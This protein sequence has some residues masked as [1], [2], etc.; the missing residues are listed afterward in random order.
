MIGNNY[1][2]IKIMIFAAIGVLGSVSAAS[3]QWPTFDASAIAQKAKSIKQQIDQQ[4]TMIKESSMVGS[5]NSAI[6]DAKA[7][8][9][10]FSLD[11]VKA[12]AAKAEKLK[13]EAE[14]IKKIKE[15]IDKAKKQYEEKKKQFEEYQSKLQEAKSKVTDTIDDAKSKVEDAKGMVNEAKDMAASAKDTVASAGDLAKSQI[16]STM[17]KTGV[18][19]AINNGK[20]TVGQVSGKVSSGVSGAKASVSGTAVQAATTISAAGV[21]GAV[22]GA[23]PVVNRQ[24]FGQG[25]ALGAEKAE[26][27]ALQSGALS[28]ADVRAEKLINAAQTND[29]SEFVNSSQKVYDAGEKVPTAI[30][31]AKLEALSAKPAALEASTTR[32]AVEKLNVSGTKLN[33]DSLTETPA[34]NLKAVSGRVSTAT[35][36]QSAVLAA[37]T[38]VSASPALSETT[39]AS[40]VKAVAAPKAVTLERS[41]ATLA[42]SAV[43]GTINRRAFTQPSASTV[44]KTP[45]LINS[46]PAAVKEVTGTILKGS[47]PVQLKTL[48][49]NVW[50]EDG[51]T[52]QYARLSRS[53][54]ISFAKVDSDTCQDFN[55]SIMNDG[56]EVEV[57]PKSIARFCCIKAEQVNDPK[58]IQDCMKKMLAIK[59]D[60]DAE[61][62]QVGEGYYTVFVYDSKL[63]GVREALENIQFATSYEEDRFK[64]FK[65]SMKN[66]STGQDDISV[67]SLTNKEL[68]F[69]L[70][71][72][73][74]IYASAVVN[75]SIANLSDIKSSALDEDTEIGLNNT[76]DNN[77]SGSVSMAE[78]EYY[79]MPDNLAIKCG[80]NIKDGSDGLSG[81][82]QKLVEERN[83]KDAK[84][85]EIALNFYENIMAD[86][87]L[88]N[89]GKSF[90]QKLLSAQ[91]EEKELE[92]LQDKLTSAATLHEHVEGA[93]AAGQ[94]IQKMLDAVVKMYASSISLSSLRNVPRLTPPSTDGAEG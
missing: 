62:A 77:Y 72:L 92:E 89:M 9:S 14:K 79:V 57:I 46:S 51:A 82:Y 7:S 67:I 2:K 94:E 30:E 53:E 83:A 8:L 21:S 71:R 26:A 22:S 27:A 15:D 35:N 39:A 45:E 50:L 87:I 34:V 70:D 88:K 90:R 31:G 18:S 49:K 81:C 1:K 86:D 59:H 66:S 76:S 3:A 20:S 19:S 10:K 47:A 80:I 61:M 58:V 42:P 93:A 33:T 40:A 73:R 38:A 84:D 91:F 68:L 23:A 4:V 52:P 65:E 55:P 44:K 75:D 78:E 5:I 25:V 6:G 11:K 13:K 12:A 17:D 28:A 43:S 32:Q 64:K 16:S 60:E 24:A 29:F 85:A 48:D 54:T 36:V 69:L 56:V 74:R 37:P 63:G 41:S